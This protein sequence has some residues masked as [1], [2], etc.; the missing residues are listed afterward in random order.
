[1]SS[2]RTSFTPNNYN[3]NI[4]QYTDKYNLILICYNIDKEIRRIGIRERNKQ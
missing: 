3:Y 1:M 2:G 4:T